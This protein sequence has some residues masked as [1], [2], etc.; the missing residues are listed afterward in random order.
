[1]PEFGP[2]PLLVGNYLCRRVLSQPTLW[3]ARLADYEYRAGGGA[4]HLVSC[5]RRRKVGG[6]DGVHVSHAHHDQVYA[7]GRGKLENALCRT[8]E[9]ELKLVRSRKA[10]SG[11]T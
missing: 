1:M 4:N 11:G 9:P 5:V 8:A 3:W 2:A 7:T 10:D 6:Y